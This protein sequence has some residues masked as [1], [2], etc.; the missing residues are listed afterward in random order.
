[1]SD[2]TVPAIDAKQS[3]QNLSSSDGK[4]GATPDEITV[5]PF[6]LSILGATIAV[7]V[8]ALIGANFVTLINFKSL[9]LLLPIDEKKYYFKYGRDSSSSGKAFGMSRVSLADLGIDGNPYGWPYSM[10]DKDA[11]ELSFQGLSNWFAKSTSGSYIWLRQVLYDGLS[12]PLLKLMHPI[13]LFFMAPLVLG[14]TPVIL[15]F[16]SSYFVLPFKG[17]MLG[18]FGWMWTFLG[19]F[20]AW[21]PM[22]MGCNHFIQYLQVL[23]LFIIYPLIVDIATVKKV[24]QE[25]TWWLGLMFGFLIVV[26]GFLNLGIIPG[27]VMSLGWVFMVIKQL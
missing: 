27:I 5:G 18:Y 3:K 2:S 9:E 1:M 15:P 10:Y 17:F 16:I 22:M 26:S 20:L 24:L 13:V 19:L 12:S 23:A 7:L 4:V 14:F 8:F 25:N 21:T 6:M 11:H